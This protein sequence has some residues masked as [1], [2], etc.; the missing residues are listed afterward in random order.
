MNTR[1]RPKL[2]ATKSRRSQG[3]A[4]MISKAKSPPAILRSSAPGSAALAGSS[5]TVSRHSSLPSIGISS[6][7]QP[8]SSITR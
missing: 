2:S 7:Q 1:P 4:D 8:V 6:A 5:N 3:N